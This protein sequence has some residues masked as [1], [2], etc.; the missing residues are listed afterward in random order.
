MLLLEGSSKVVTETLYRLLTEECK[1]NTWE[2]GDFHGSSWY[3]SFDPKAENKILIGLRLAASE[4]VQK[5]KGAVVELVTKMCGDGTVIPKL[6]EADSERMEEADIYVKVDGYGEV[7]SEEDLD[8]AAREKLMRRCTTFGSLYLFCMMPVFG[9][10]FEKANAGKVYEPQPI[11]YRRDERMYV[12]A[13]KDNVCVYTSVWFGGKDDLLFGRIFLQ[14]FV[15]A[16]KR[17]K[18]IAGAPGC[19]MSDK[20]P[21]ALDG[22]SGVESEDKEHRLWITLV[23][24][25]PRHTD[26]AALQH[27]VQMLLNF[28]N[29]VQY[30]IKCART[31]MNER[32]RARHAEL[33]KV[34]NRA[35][36]DHTGQSLIRI[37]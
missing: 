19:N 23:L 27:T 33:I 22:V 5:V 37:V 30:H 16:K 13:S 2:L 20:R 10:L 12:G 11:D 29:Y 3:V 31:F 14:E 35:K 1:K 25:V 4:Q 36:T 8:K 21:A 6:S 34:L 15:D 26:P 24:Q 18:S 32:M 7:S 9:E 28:R 17:E